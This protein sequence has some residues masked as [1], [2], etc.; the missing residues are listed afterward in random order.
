MNCVKWKLRRTNDWTEQQRRGGAWEPSPL[1]EGETREGGTSLIDA[2][3]E[4]RS[5]AGLQVGDILGRLDF[6]T[7]DQWRDPSQD[8]S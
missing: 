3:F 4:P 8:L 1:W 7:H 2:G 5:I 6:V